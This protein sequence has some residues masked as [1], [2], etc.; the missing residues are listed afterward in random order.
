MVTQ[1]VTLLVIPMGKKLHNCQT[2][3]ALAF[4]DEVARSLCRAR[5]IHIH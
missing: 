4:R 1:V 3:L 2:C 5:G